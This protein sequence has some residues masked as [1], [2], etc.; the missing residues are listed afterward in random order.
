MLSLNV[1]LQ[2]QHHCTWGE[3]ACSG[4]GCH[5]SLDYCATIILLSLSPHSECNISSSSVSYLRHISMSCH[6]LCTHTLSC[7]QCPAS[8]HSHVVVTMAHNLGIS[9]LNNSIICLLFLGRRVG[10]KAIYMNPLLLWLIA[11]LDYIC[12]LFWHAAFIWWTIFMT[13]VVPMIYS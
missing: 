6:M 8:C 5:V 7:A 4:I 11:L 9:R 10:M 13:I 1:P 3:C 12:I 2:S